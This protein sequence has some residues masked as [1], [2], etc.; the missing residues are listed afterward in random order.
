M[1]C[2]SVKKRYWNLKND[3]IFKKTHIDKVDDVSIF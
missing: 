2:N 1:G 3:Y